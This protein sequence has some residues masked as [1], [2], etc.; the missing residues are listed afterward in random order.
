VRCTCF[1]ARRKGTGHLHSGI[2]RAGP[3]KIGTGANWK[4]GISRL[5]AKHSPRNHK[6]CGSAGLGQGPIVHEENAFLRGV[7]QTGTARGEA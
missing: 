6:M 5:K 4:L 1:L 3:E 7:S 2:T